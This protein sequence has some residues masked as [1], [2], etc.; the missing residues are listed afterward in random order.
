MK[1]KHSYTLCIG[2]KSDSRASQGVTE[3]TC[4]APHGT[5]DHSQQCLVLWPLQELSETGHQIK[6]YRLP[7]TGVL[8]QHDA[9]PQTACVMCE[10][11]KSTFISCVSVILHTCQPLLLMIVISIGRPE[12]KDRLRIAF[13]QVKFPRWFKVAWPQWSFVFVSSKFR[14]DCII[15]TVYVSV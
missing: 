8:L 2:R 3:A 7:S 10:V 9:R 5:G 11:L 12:S 1:P 15:W 4:W 6:S 14:T 13:A